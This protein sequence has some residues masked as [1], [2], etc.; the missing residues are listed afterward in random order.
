MGRGEFAWNDISAASYW[1]YQ[2]LREHFDLLAV[3]PA[4]LHPKDDNYLLCQQVHSTPFANL[5]KREPESEKYCSLF[6][7]KWELRLFTCEWPLA[8]I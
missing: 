5:K 7:S 4:A 8:E 6:H 3:K 1:V 2:L